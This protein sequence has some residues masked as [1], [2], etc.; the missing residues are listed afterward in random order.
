MK[1]RFIEYEQGIYI[2]L[3][4]TYD[5]MLNSSECFV[6]VPINEINSS[7]GRAIL[8]INTVKISISEANEIT[9]KNTLVA[10]MV[11]FYGTD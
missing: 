3:G 5:P 7:I 1:L 11:L 8:D 6:A 2:V 9:D 4:I 10:L